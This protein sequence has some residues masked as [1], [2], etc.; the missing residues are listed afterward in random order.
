VHAHARPRGDAEHPGI[1]RKHVADHAMMTARSGIVLKRMQEHGAEAATLP[2]VNYSHGEFAGRSQL[3]A[4][5]P[6]T[7]HD[8]AD[9][10]RTVDGDQH[11]RSRFPRLFEHYAYDF[12]VEVAHRSHESVIARARR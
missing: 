8:L 7:A 1:L 5:V 12:F 10:A 3:G 11:T 9:V 2:R 6:A 4:Y